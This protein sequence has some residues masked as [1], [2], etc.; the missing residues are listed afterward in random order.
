MKKIVSALALGAMV[1]GAASAKTSVSLSYRNGANFFDYGKSYSSN[2]D[3]AHSLME[4][5]NLNG[6]NVGNDNLKFTASGDVLGFTL[7]TA[8]NLTANTIDVKA[9]EGD[10]TFGALHTKFGFNADGNFLGGF[11]IKKYSPLESNLGGET[12][13]PGS[14]FK[15]SFANAVTSITTIGATETRLFA[16][17]DYTLAFTNSDASVK[18]VGTWIGD[19]VTNWSN[20]DANNDQIIDGYGRT[21]W[22]AQIAEGNGK[23]PYTGGDIV[24]KDAMGWV[25]AAHVNLPSVFEVA[26][27]LKGIPYVAWNQDNSGKNTDNGSGDV[28]TIGLQKQNL[29]DGDR[30]EI[31]VFVPA[32]YFKL[33]AIKNVSIVAGGAVSI[34]DWN[35][36]DFAFNVSANVNLFDGRLGITYDWNL[37][38]ANPDNFNHSN[39]ASGMI[40]PTTKGIGATF[41]GTS[42]GTGLGTQSCTV[43]YNDLSVNFKLNNTFTAGLDILAL[44]DLGGAFGDDGDGARLDYQDAAGTNLSVT[45][46]VQIFAASKAFICAGINF[47]LEGLGREDEC[48]IKS[49]AG[50]SNAKNT[51]GDLLGDGINFGISVP[52]LFRVQL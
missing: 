22:Y 13:K 39:S 45:P 42:F 34:Y 20:G 49:K 44:T 23:E 18:F 24:Q 8:P 15:N 27:I 11:R 33:M 38:V 4:W 29:T 41:H 35:M 43:M 14:Y 6:H 51:T 21:G 32:L 37:S 30:E 48:G 25:A 12:A 3:E 7:T 28:D 16:T 36:S 47:T 31:G 19:N 52:V 26:A 5:F 2:S 40:V 50:V 1:F 17:G 46:Y 9:I 10:A